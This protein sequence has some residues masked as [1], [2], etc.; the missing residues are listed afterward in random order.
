MNMP[1]D[2]SALMIVIVI[3]GF[4]LAMVAAGIVFVGISALIL[5]YLP[6]C[7]YSKWLEEEFFQTEQ[8]N[9]DPDYDWLARRVNK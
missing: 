3:S 4:F 7:F 5:H 6:N 1:I 8:L 9:Y 2:V